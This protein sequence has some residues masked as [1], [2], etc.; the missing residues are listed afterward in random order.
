MGYFS[1]GTEGMD[2]EA[3]YCARCIHRDGPDGESGCAVWS[4]HLF[5]NDDEDLRPESPLHILIPR[6][7]DGLSNEQCRLFMDRAV[8][9]RDELMERLKEAASAL[10]VYGRHDV[11]TCALPRMV[12]TCGFD[13]A[14]VAANLGQPSLFGSS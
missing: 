3:R 10:R 7:A 5:V 8:L 4:A 6:S 1:N 11:E 14:I 13:D 12:C 9:V 2:Y